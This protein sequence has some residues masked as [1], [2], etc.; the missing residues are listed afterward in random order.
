MMG[1]NHPGLSASTEWP[2][3]GQLANGQWPICTQHCWYRVTLRAHS[4]HALGTRPRVAGVQLRRTMK[5]STVGTELV[6]LPAGRFTAPAGWGL[7]HRRV[8]DAADGPPHG[9]CK[10][11]GYP[12]LCCT[13]PF[14][15]SAG[16]KRQSP[17]V[18]ALHPCAPPSQVGCTIGFQPQTPQGRW[19]KPTHGLL[20]FQMLLLRHA[21]RLAPDGRSSTNVRRQTHV[22]RLHILQEVFPLTDRRRPVIPLQKPSGQNRG[23]LRV[24]LAS[25]LPRI[26][27]DYVGDF[28]GRGSIKVGSA[29]HRAIRVQPVFGSLSAAL[30]GKRGRLG[31]QAVVEQS[32]ALTTKDRQIFGGLVFEALVGSMVDVEAP[33]SVADLTSAGGSFQGTESLLLPGRRAEIGFVF[34]G[35]GNKTPPAGQRS[36]LTYQRRVLPSAHT[37]TSR[38][39]RRVEDSHVW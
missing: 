16:L 33:L 2:I 25:S 4:D 34:S 11:H 31:R 12:A 32:V 19:G 15:S 5:I 38:C 22:L 7:S 18:P 36:G 29:L 26:S 1:T 30:P 28:L 35:E 13:L 9:R 37:G 6:A 27:A 20:L 24:W 23:R 3:N 14:S 39:L 21:K 8:N 17:A 10:G